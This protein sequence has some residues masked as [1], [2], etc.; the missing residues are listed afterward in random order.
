VSQLDAL[1]YIPYEGAE[2]ETLGLFVDAVEFLK[3]RVYLLVAYY[4]KDG[5]THRGPCM[6][7]IVRLAGLAA[8]SLYLREHGET[9][10]I[11]VVEGK[12]YLLLVCLVVGDKY[13]FHVYSKDPL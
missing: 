10:A 5:R 7:T 8:A 1:F 6:A 4:G 3:Q 12:E 11:E 2:T 9:T 13:G